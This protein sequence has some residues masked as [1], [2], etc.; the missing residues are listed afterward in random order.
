MKTA[1]LH[2]AD[3]D[4]GCVGPTQT[5]SRSLPSPQSLNVDHITMTPTQ[6]THPDDD[7]DVEAC[8]LYEWTQNLSAEDFSST[9]PRVF[10][11]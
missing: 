7:E 3:N 6:G 2:A 1:Y 10:S 11:H 8:Q 9:P 4:D 5:A